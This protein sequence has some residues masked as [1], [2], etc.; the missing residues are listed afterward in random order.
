MTSSISE[1]IL[2]AYP[3]N[4]QVTL[5]YKENKTDCI[6]TKK[7]FTNIFKYFIGLYVSKTSRQSNLANKTWLV[8]ISLL[9]RDKLQVFQCRCHYLR[10]KGTRE[11]IHFYKNVNSTLCQV[12]NICLMHLTLKSESV[13]HV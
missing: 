12:A 6:F 1:N 10:Y 13:I 8:T 5:L 4:T 3:L 11:V 7:R 2:I 9:R